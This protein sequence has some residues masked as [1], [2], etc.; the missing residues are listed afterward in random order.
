MQEEDAAMEVL[1]SLGMKGHK[2]R[3]TISEID[4]P[5]R[6]TQGARSNPGLGI[7]PGVALDLTALDEFGN[8]CD[9]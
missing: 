8:P 1:L 9:F 2:A 6:I 5:P 4:S 7:Q 3:R